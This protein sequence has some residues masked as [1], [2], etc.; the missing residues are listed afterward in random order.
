LS[1]REIRKVTSEFILLELCD[2]LAKLRY[3]EL[4]VQ[5]VELLRRDK[6]FQIVPAT[7]ELLQTAWDLY[8]SRTDKEWG[9]TD[10][11][12]FVIMQRFDLDTALS[13]DRHFEQA[14]YKA[15]LLK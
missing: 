3:R 12:S 14:G 8:R 6:L 1:G 9:L 7:G 11:T 13:A 5:V 4:A 15:L 2:G 10:C